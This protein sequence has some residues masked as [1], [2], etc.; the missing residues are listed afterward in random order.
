MGSIHICVTHYL[1]RDVFETAL[2]KYKLMITV[3]SYLCISHFTGTLTRSIN[4]EITL[5][6]RSLITNADNR[7][8]GYGDTYRY[9]ISLYA[10]HFLPN[11]SLAFP[12]HPIVYEIEFSPHTFQRHGGR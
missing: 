4:I 11:A 10:N 2:S 1:G 6:V 9:Y 12:Q 8:K 5:R 7:G 3:A